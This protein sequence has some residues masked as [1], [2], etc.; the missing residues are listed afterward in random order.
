MLVPQISF[1]FVPNTWHHRR[2]VAAFFWDINM[3]LSGIQWLLWIQQVLSECW[4]CC[5]FLS[6]KFKKKIVWGM[7]RHSASESCQKSYFKMPC[8]N[9]YDK[10][11]SPSHR[12][13]QTEA[14]I[15]CKV[16]MIRLNIMKLNLVF[17]TF[18]IILLFTMEKA[19]H[20][21]QWDDQVL[22]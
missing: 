5:F 16:N 20:C 7:N 3:L 11:T 12:T 17:I 6:Q 1:L 9:L 22:W 4:N 14:L 21:N 8:A 13:Q 10:D 15:N 19:S 18:T 2:A